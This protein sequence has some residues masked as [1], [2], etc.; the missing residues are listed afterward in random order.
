M[1]HFSKNSLVVCICLT[2]IIS[3]LYLR[4]FDSVNNTF[5]LLNTLPIFTFLDSK[6][7][8]HRDDVSVSDEEIIVPYYQE[9]PINVSLEEINSLNIIINNCNSSEVFITEVCKELSKDGIKFTFT[10]DCNN[11]NIDNAIIITLDQQ[12]MSG[13]GTAVF[14]PLENE[15]LG[16][17]DALALAAK[18][19]F[20]EKGFL[21]DRISCGQTD[22]MESSEH[23][24]NERVPTSTEKGI[25]KTLDTSFVTVSF[26]AESVNATLTAS[27]IEATLTRYYSYII[28]DHENIDL[29]YC[30]GPDET[31][32]EISNRLNTTNSALITFNKIKNKKVALTGDA[33]LNPK[34]AD[35]RQF[36]QYVPTNLYIDKTLWSK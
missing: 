31:Y 24:I 7:I 2:I 11:I 28:S 25:D 30:A 1:S 23:T 9:D 32:N 8:N 20:Y 15:R 14:A 10:Q 17:S 18:T 12:Y 5:T 4:V 34:I 35:I 33:I 22:F 13:L 27:S 26:G 16:N 19:A 29:I 3:T 6:D 21:I 36:N